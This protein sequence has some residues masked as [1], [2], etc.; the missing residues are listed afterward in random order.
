MQE[1][2]KTTALIV[3]I[4]FLVLGLGIILYAMFFLNSRGLP[5]PIANLVGV[6]EVK[7]QARLSWCDTRITSIELANG[8]RVYQEGLKWYADGPMEKGE[9]DFIA[10]EKW[11]GSHC[12]VPVTSH[13]AEITEEALVAAVQFIDGARQDFR[14]DGKGIMTWKGQSFSSPTLEAAFL[15]LMELPVVD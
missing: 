6:A 4:N 10:V 2:D 11:F 9:L 7:K 15:E 5:A 3:K 1:M 8:R 13:P 12:K 14:A